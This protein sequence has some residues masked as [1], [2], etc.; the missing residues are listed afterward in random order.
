M[1][2]Y[3]LH[4]ALLTVSILFALLVVGGIAVTT[5]VIVSD[6]MR[7]VAAE[8]TSR[9]ALSGEAVLRE[10]VANSELQVSESG[11]TGEAAVASAT[12]M[13]VR[14][15][16]DALA[17]QGMSQGAAVLYDNQLRLLWASSTPS[18][19]PS[20]EAARRAALASGIS[21]QAIGRGGGLLSGLFTKARLGEVVNHIPVRLP[22]DR[23]GVLDIV[24]TPST[25]DHVIDSVRRP[26]MILAFAA[27]IIM[28]LL[29]QTSLLWVLGL[30]NNLR[31]AT[32][33]IDAGRLDDRLP[34]VG[35]NEISD[36]ARSLN[37]LIERLQHRAEGQS[38]FIADASHELATPVA[39][40]RGYTSILRAWG[41]DDPKV[42]GEAIEAIDRESKRMARLTGDLL[43][44]LHVDQGLVLRSDKFD[45]NALVR[46]RLAATASRWIEKD[47]DFSG[48]ED[49]S[50]LMVGDSDRVEDIVSILLDNAAK[51]T[52]ARGSIGVETRKRRDTVVID[53]RDSGQGIPPED[54]PRI[55]DRFFRSDASRAAGEG[56]FGLG[57]AILKSI[58]ESM[59]GEIGVE[60]TV[61]EGT[62][63][64]VR[65][66]KGRL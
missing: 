54:L 48:P 30:V 28:V 47:I 55:F 62:A 58:V 23:P 17:R 51:Y 66:P 34:V 57:L 35:N 3:P 52:P 6:G 43:N 16:P 37:H 19:T 7:G 25:E 38:R 49:D 13:V 26:M 12:A 32:D 64:T 50:L 60:S 65:L 22:G 41:A 24:H 9:L 21:S 45:L 63:F 10:V 36:L 4:A 11:L 33:S 15:L 40:I 44:L 56:G 18:D 29:M 1:R 42:R 2:R 14:D 39:G 59:G 8:A 5:Y 53:V 61:G 46:E 27:L 31:K 20:Q